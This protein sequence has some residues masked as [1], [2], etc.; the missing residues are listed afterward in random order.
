[1]D[2]YRQHASSRLGYGPNECLLDVI[3]R[4]HTSVKIVQLLKAQCILLT[5]DK[6]RSSLLG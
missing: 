4:E 2:I 1:M 5:S 6:N 3:G